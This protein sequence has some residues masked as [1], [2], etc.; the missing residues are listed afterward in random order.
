MDIDQIVDMMDLEERVNDT[1]TK[2]KA[3]VEE[4][5]EFFKRLQLSEEVDKIIT[6]TDELMEE[7]RQIEQLEN[8]FTGHGLGP[9]NFLQG[10]MAY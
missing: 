7:A 1:L 4:A 9:G 10:P 3:L 8:S 2:S 5:E 6:R